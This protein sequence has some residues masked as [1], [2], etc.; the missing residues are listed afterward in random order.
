MKS[1]K[2]T[3]RKEL[4][5]LEA[6]DASIKHWVNDIEKRFKNGDSF[7]HT[8]GLPRWASDLTYVNCDASSCA[9]C[10]KYA[11]HKA[12]RKEKCPLER[13]G[14]SCNQYLN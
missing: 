10:Q 12:N 3:E 13:A 6:L 5:E 11:C 7:M 4:T 9:L 8:K 14:L 1:N 2:K